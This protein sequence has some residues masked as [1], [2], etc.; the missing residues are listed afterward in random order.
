MP[1]TTFPRITSDRC[2]SRISTSKDS[3]DDF[4]KPH[5]KN[6][7]PYYYLELYYYFLICH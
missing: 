4:S 2:R 6:L 1:I 3:D 7:S 5:I